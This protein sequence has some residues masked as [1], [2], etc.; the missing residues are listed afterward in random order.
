MEFKTKISVLLVDDKTEFLES[1]A[2]FLALEPG[3]KVVGYAQSVRY[4]LEQIRQL[5]PDLV[6]MD[7]AM[8]GMNGLTASTLIKAFPAA[9]KVVIVSM[10]DSPEYQIAARVAQADGFVTKS[11]FGS[12]LP[13]LIQTLFKTS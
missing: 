2:R 1:A 8:P 12:Q 10:Y 6:L 4:A 9:P 7:L 5:R 13:M 11:E 3:V